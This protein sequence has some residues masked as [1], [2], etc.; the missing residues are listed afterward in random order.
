MRKETGICV[1]LP[2]RPSSIVAIWDLDISL[3]LIFDFSRLSRTYVPLRSPKD[4]GGQEGDLTERTI[5]IRVYQVYRT[6]HSKRRSGLFHSTC[7]P[8]HYLGLGIYEW[9][10][11]AF[12]PVFLSLVCVSRSRLRTYEYKTYRRYS[13]VRILPG[14]RYEN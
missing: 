9:Y 12:G 13:Y 1:F 8:S 3:V 5:R 14:F 10:I 11:A 7:N 4:R 2:L 6:Y